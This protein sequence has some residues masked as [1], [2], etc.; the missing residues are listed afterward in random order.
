ASVW[1]DRNKPVEQMTWTPGQPMIIRDKLVADGGWIGRA[2]V[3]CFN[4]YRP[5]IIKSGD[6]GLAGPWL[7]HVR[8]VFPDD[9]DHIIRWPSHRV[10]RPAEKINH[11]LVLAGAQGIDKDTILEPVKHAVGPWNFSEPS[12]QQIMGRFNGFL[13]S[14]VMRINEARDL[15]EFD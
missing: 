2:D 4:L 11:A 6:A 10:Q 15:G 13:K 8:K 9:T 12:P 5:P 1:L 7:D 14:V 3:R